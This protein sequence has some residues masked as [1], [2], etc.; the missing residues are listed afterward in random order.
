MRPSLVS[1]LTLCSAAVL[2][3]A[4]AGCGDKAPEGASPHAPLADATGVPPAALPPGALP[5]GALPPGTLPP[6]MT[7]E[8]QE[9]VKEAMAR[10]GRE[11]GPALPA[12]M[13]PLKTSDVELYMKLAPEMRKAGSD[14][15]AIGRLAG[16]H[17]LTAPQWAL[18]QGRVMGTAMALSYGTV[19]EQLKADAEV[20]KPYKDKI[21]AIVQGR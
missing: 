18:L 15:A 16:E 19:P 1:R 2:T 7:Q 8:L 3:L 9:R 21:L 6:G 11:G 4:L 10:H 17:G 13:P 20:V 12:G 5:P 14:M